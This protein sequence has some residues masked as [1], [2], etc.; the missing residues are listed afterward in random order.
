M[1]KIPLIEDFSSHNNTDFLYDRIIVVILS[2]SLYNNVLTLKRPCKS[3]LICLSVIYSQE[4]RRD[5]S[6]FI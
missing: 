2:Q 1:L 6:R 5:S 3:I 4:A